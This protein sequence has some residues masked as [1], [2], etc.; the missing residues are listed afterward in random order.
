MLQ[1]SKKQRCMRHAAVITS[2]T[3]VMLLCWPS[4]GQD[5]DALLQKLKQGIEENQ[6]KLLNVRV[7]GTCLDES[8]NLTNRQWEFD[9][10]DSVTAWYERVPSGLGRRRI[11]H[12]RLVSPWA[13]GTAP[14]LESAFTTVYD[15]R[16]TKTFWTRNGPISNAVAVLRGQINAGMSAPF[17][18]E[19]ATGWNVSLWGGFDPPN[20]MSDLFLFPKDQQRATETMLDG[21]P[22]IEFQ[23]ILP[24]GIRALA[25]YFDPA[26]GY[27]PLKCERAGGDGVVAY[28]W[29]VQS[30]VEAAPGV[31]YP[32]SATRE[33]T[34]H[35]GELNAQVMYQAS[36]VVANDPKFSD[37]L[38][39]LEFPPK[40]RVRD[41]I[42][43]NTYVVPSE[44][45]EQPVS[46]NTQDQIQLAAPST[47]GPGGSGSRVWVV[48]A[49]IG[50]AVIVIVAL[51]VRLRRHNPRG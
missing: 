39:M 19:F 17:M 20:R 21:T 31:F 44:L 30:L 13:N 40:T 42:T 6:K 41:L 16:I 12:K 24:N 8:M 36:S 33:Y 18:H 3:M 34:L 46:G 4:Q 38:F 45:P 51:A 25:Y 23:V 37:D 27:A 35:G 26:R 49:G 48:V 32:T 1:P 22:C 28:S 47:T 43:T 9:G 10:S 11:E 29:S 2:V 5:Q 15:G 50:I 14:F 7:E